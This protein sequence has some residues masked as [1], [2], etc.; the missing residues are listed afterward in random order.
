[1]MNEQSQQAPPPVTPEE[2]KRNVEAMRAQVVELHRMRQAVVSSAVDQLR[3]AGRLFGSERAIRGVFRMGEP[4]MSE[5]ER[6]VNGEEVSGGALVSPAELERLR[7]IERD[8]EGVL[9]EVAKLDAER[10]RN[11]KLVEQIDADREKFNAE[12]NRL[13]EELEGRGQPAAQLTDE[14]AG[15]LALLR[16]QLVQHGAPAEVIAEYES[17]ASKTRRMISAED[18]ERMDRLHELETAVLP[19]RDRLR[20]E[21]DGLRAAVIQKDAAIVSWRQRAEAAE[22]RRGDAGEDADTGVKAELHGQ[23]E[24]LEAERDGL[25][26]RCTALVAQ[27]GER[28]ELL[29]QLAQ[30]G[31]RKQMIAATTALVRI[32]RLERLSKAKVRE[33]AAEVGVTLEAAEAGATPEDPPQAEETGEGERNQAL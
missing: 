12:V 1:M 29:A 21:V 22:Q 4:E 6:R 17:L 8:A 31:D 16:S 33:I 14:E 26:E 30:D 23:I 27:V 11:D 7:G 3:V 19:E 28:E 32:L 13:R 2:R 25:Q 9:A 15:R 10:A 24:A 18:S 5:L 20:A